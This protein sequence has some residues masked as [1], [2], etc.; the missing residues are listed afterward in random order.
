M[1][2]KTTY[3]LFIS[4]LILASC[5]DWLDL[6]PPDGLV[7]DEYW[8]TKED[9]KATLMGAYQQLAQMDELL[10]QYGEVRADMID[11]DDNIPPDI[12]QIMDGNI[13][14]DNK[15]CDWSGFYKIINYCNLVL[16]FN[17]VVFE[18][19]PTYS[20]IQKQG[21]EAEALFLRSLSYFYLVRIFK[22]VPYTTES[23]VSDSV[24]VYLPA[25]KDTEIL[26]AI[27]EDLRTARQIASNEYGSVENNLGRASKNAI[28]ALLADICLWNFEYEECVSYIEEIENSLVNLVVGPQWYTIFYPGNTLEG[29]FEVQY[30]ENLDQGNNLFRI[31]Y[32]QDNYTASLNAVELLSRESAREIIRGDGSYRS[33]DLKIWKYCGAAG[34]AQSVR[35]SS[36]RSSGNWIIYRYA[37]ILLM[38]AEAL[39][40]LGEYDE[41][42]EY[43]NRIRT[44]ANMV[45]KSS[46]DNP[47]AFEDLVLEERAKELAFE[48]KRWF[49]LL[50]MGRRNNFARKDKLI[51]IIVQKVPSN[52]RLVLVSKLSNPLGWYFPVSDEELERNKELDQNPYYEGY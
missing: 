43:V 11:R 37:E 8:K 52:K 47:D 48:G 28:N 38:K 3:G 45:T 21:V 9:V 39:S 7:Q 33:T 24:N 23:T 19:D 25:S 34:D 16:A 40:Q 49:D 32:T 13:Y 14:P 41:A 31:T 42:I 44:R 36:E 4:F 51:S 1:I 18:L 10:F 46:P 50:R 30:D 29:I 26:E 15:L 22:D 20:E 27:K 12:Q 17:P 5:S 2:R 35:P 6:R